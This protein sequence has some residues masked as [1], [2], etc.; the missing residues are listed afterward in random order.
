MAETPEQGLESTNSKEDEGGIRCRLRDRNLLRKRKAE[1]EEKETNQ[2]DF[3]VESP[4]KRSKAT[5]KSSSKKRGRPRKLETTPLIPVVQEK[6]AVI[7]E[8]PGVVLVPEAAGTILDQK[9]SF[10]TPLP[11]VASEPAPLQ[12]SVQSPVFV[13]TLSSPALVNPAPDMTTIQDSA[14]E[15][16]LG[17]VL[18]QD[19]TLYPAPAPQQLDNLYAESQNNEASDQILNQDVGR[20]DEMN[21]APPADKKTDED[22]GVEDLSETRLMTEQSKMYPLPSFSSMPLSEEY[23]PG[24]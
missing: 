11:A 23:L 10:L 14:Q 3:G 22:I 21:K 5:V 7:Q 2:W 1:A 9:T 16:F 13:S 6:E 18:S 17:P 15:V 4:S 24:N 20:N 8:D 19:S 12:E